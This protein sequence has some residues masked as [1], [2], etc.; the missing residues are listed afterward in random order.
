VDL[1][2]TAR[3]PYGTSKKEERH[4]PKYREA[5]ILNDKFVLFGRSIV[6]DEGRICRTSIAL[7]T[8]MIDL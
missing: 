6:D 7:F 3:G 1:K 2:A 4:V 8:P 5:A